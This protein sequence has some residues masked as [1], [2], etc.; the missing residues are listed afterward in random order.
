MPVCLI[1]SS[2]IFILYEHLQTFDILE[3]FVL[4][5]CNHT[6]KLKKDKTEIN[7]Y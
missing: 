7:Y 3:Y 1:Q 5:T 6:D 2:P 4:K